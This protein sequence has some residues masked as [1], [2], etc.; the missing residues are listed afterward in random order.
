MNLINENSHRILLADDNFDEQFLAERA[1]KK[2]LSKGSTVRVV[3]SGNKAIA[4]MI[5]EGIYGDRSMYPFPSLVITDLTMPDGDGFNV[6]EFL[7]SNPGWSVVPRIVFS[8]SENEEDVRTAF[9]LG[10]SAYHIK[11]SHPGGLESQMRQILEYWTTSRVPPVDETGRLL[12][13]NS[14]GPSSR[15][16]LPK[17]GGIMKRPRTNV[18]F[19]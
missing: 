9:L 17:R 8:S 14:G 6:L 18:T 10:A 1:L 11:G 13:T 15:Y 4:Y 19:G 3:D 7:Q 2:I 16:P 12:E 5:G